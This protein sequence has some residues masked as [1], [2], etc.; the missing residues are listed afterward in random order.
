[1]ENIMRKQTVHF[2]LFFSPNKLIFKFYFP[3]NF[4]NTAYLNA[5]IS[6]LNFGG[7]L[8]KVLAKVSLKL[9]IVN[10]KSK[11]CDMEEN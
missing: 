2:N 6:Y 7:D 3:I 11:V 5:T 10:P 4:W 1:M 9:V 8:A